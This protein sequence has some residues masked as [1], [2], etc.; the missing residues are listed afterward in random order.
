[1]H[2]N[3]ISYKNNMVLQNFYFK[4]LKK[5]EFINLIS[6][7]KTTKDIYVKVGHYQKLRAKQQFLS[8]ILENN[9]SLTRTI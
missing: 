3:E 1:M 6:Q 9:F 2:Q 5:T 8:Y 4:C 7:I